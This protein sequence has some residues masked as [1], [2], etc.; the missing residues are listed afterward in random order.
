M[1]R[2]TNCS[3]CGEGLDLHRIFK[4]AYCQKCSSELSKQYLRKHKY[5]QLPDYKEKAKVRTVTLAAIKSGKIERKPCEVCGDERSEIHHED[6]SDPMKIRWLCK[7]HHED[8]HH[9]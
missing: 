7:W 4:Y 1:R 8:V 9:Q 5:H 6:Y 2:Q 3:K